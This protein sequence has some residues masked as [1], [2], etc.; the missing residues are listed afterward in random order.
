MKIE[1]G[2]GETPTKPG[3][4]TCDIRDLPGID[5]VCVAWEIDQHVQPG[6]VA[7]IFSRHFF[8]HL[9]FQQGER[10]MSVWYDILQPDGIC[11]IMVPNMD[12]HIQQWLHP[13]NAK[14]FNHACAGFW[15]WQRGTFD[16]TWDIHKSGY[17]H[18]SL[19]KVMMMAGFR[20]IQRLDDGRGIHLHLTGIK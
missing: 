8:E 5:F 18:Q 13:K 4:L 2:C 1:F 10:L 7:E 14:D 12:Y 19:S 16:D 17:N 9:T 11:E 15:G 20:N 3:Y 6:T